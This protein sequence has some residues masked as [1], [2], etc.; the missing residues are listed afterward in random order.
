[1]KAVKIRGL[2]GF[3]TVGHISLGIPQKMDNRSSRLL[4]GLIHPV[5]VLIR[6]RQKHAVSVIDITGNDRF[7][8]RTHA[9]ILVGRKPAVAIGGHTVSSI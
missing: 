6:G 2:K 3:N 4:T 8:L 9:G 7:L 5:A 1:M